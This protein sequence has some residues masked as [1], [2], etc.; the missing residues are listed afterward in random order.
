MLSVVKTMERLEARRLRSLGWS[1]KEI[2]GHLAVSRASVSTWVRDVEL[3][4]DAQR[5]LAERGHLG[6][7]I[8]AE[9]RSARA[10]SVRL[11]YQ[12]EGRRLA[13]ERG[14][15]YAAGCALYWAEGEKDRNSVKV[16][17][18]DPEVLVYFLAFLRREFGVRNDRIKIRCNLFADHDSRRREIEDHW[19]GRL[20]LPRTALGKTT[21]NRY[22][23]Y[24]QKK[25]TN[26]LPWGTCCLVLCSTEIVQMIYGS[27]QELGGFDRP[28]WLD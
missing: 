22:S 16:V 14:P 15:D 28:E 18:S 6:A 21:V 1:V 7:M 4:P 25:R 17:N 10:R 13:R 5:R 27:I 20:A 26:R 9:R 19:L 11:G 3:S 24:S 2:E 8:S 23:K 12:E